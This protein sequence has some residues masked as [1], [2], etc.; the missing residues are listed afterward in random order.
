MAGTGLSLF[1]GDGRQ[2]VD[3]SLYFPYRV[4][5]DELQ[6]PLILD[7]NNLRL[8]RINQDGRVETIMGNDFEEFPEEGARPQDTSLH[9]TSDAVY[10]ASG[11]L[12][13]AGH[14]IPIV[15][16]V[17]LD[18][19]VRTIAGNGEVGND[20]D[21]GAARQARLGTPW[22]VLPLDD[23]SFYVS[24]N[25]NH[26]VRFVDAMG[27]IHT[28][29]GTGQPGY[30]GDGGPAVVAQL[31]RPRF[32]KRGADGSIYLCD[33][34]NHVVRRID[35]QGMIHTVAGTGVPGYSG[36]GG[37]AVAAR[38]DTP[39]DL[40]I[41]RSG[42]LY[43][44]DSGNNVIR[45]VD[46]DGTVTTVIGSGAANFSG[47]NGSARFAAMRFPVGLTLAPDGSLWIVD[48]FNHRIR[49]VAGFDRLFPG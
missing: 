14:H 3:T 45:R 21:G 18:D 17:D 8:R 37:P 33:G 35:P 10:D 36:D 5:F 38:F 32:L 16:R 49:R 12:Y 43:I 44:A 46:R 9:H 15:F 7:W 20:G 30:A 41:A 19:R 25:E 1:N 24:D 40:E 34:D 39:S 31:N 6:R 42:D 11:R 4:L 2:A 23:G 13:L 29:A 22:G 28:V 27:I 26:V 47:D 48:T